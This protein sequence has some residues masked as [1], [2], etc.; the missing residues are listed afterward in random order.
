MSTNVLDFENIYVG[1]R[2]E[3]SAR[4]RFK[5]SE[6]G[7]G[8][9]DSA[10]G[11]IITISSKDLMQLAFQRVARDHELRILNK[12]YQVFKFD[13]FD[14][15]DYDKIST[16]ARNNYNMKV[17]L[18]EISQ[19]GYNWGTVDFENA[20]MIFSVAEKEAFEIPLA[21]VASVNTASNYNLIQVKMKSLLNSLLPE[22][23][24]EVIKIPWLKLDFMYQ[25]LSL[26][27]RYS[28]MEMLKSFETRSISMQMMGE[29]MTR[30]KNK[31]KSVWKLSRL[32]LMK[33]AK[34]SQQQHYS[35]KQ[36]NKN[37]IWIQ[38]SVSWWCNLMKSLVLRLGIL[39]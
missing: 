36:S 14:R 18:K 33:M 9:K 17:D 15:G 8:F 35:A 10:T 31:V 4:G 16:Y 13:G 30:I 6:A 39:V 22:T 21:T 3:K 2:N 19:R 12:K 29:K 25:E 1:G 28:K 37:P 24:N 20:Q 11:E 5:M 34:Q 38:L 26:R 32:H 23:F 27:A 7:M